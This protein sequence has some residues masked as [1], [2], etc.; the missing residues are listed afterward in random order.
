MKFKDYK[1]LLQL[2][3]KSRTILTIL[4]FPEIKTI[5]KGKLKVYK[6]TINETEINPEDYPIVEFQ[7]IIKIMSRVNKMVKN[8]KCSPLKRTNF[9]NFKYKLIRIILEEHKSYISEI[10]DEG[11]YYCFRI[12]DN[13]FHQPKTNFGELKIKTDYQKEYI[14]PENENIEFDNRLYYQFIINILI[15]LDKREL[16]LNEIARDEVWMVTK[17]YTKN[18]YQEFFGLYS[19]RE[20]AC[21]TILK[22][23]ETPDYKFKL[24]KETIK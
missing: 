4:M 8:K 6:K 18:L 23:G 16:S 1:D 11:E 7:E 21:E 10:T 5:K 2:S 20:K 3:P 22:E 13:Y 14:K 19:S 24:S 15:L 17:I 12:L 9:Y